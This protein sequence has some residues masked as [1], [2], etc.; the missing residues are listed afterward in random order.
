[1]ELKLHK[2]I[3]FFDLETT[4]INISK[5]RIVEISILKVNPDQSKESKTWRVNPEIPIPKESSLIHGIYDE[6]IAD[7]PTF[8]KIAPQIL[9]MIKDSDI[10]GYN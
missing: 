5:D 1:M 3:C 4:G 9:E 2:S 7:A 6:D 10:S 8:K